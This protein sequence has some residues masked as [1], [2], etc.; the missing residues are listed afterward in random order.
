MLRNE[1]Q[2]AT[3]EFFEALNARLM[4][5]LRTFEGAW[6]PRFVFGLQW[7]ITD[8]CNLRCKHCYIDRAPRR[9]LPLQDLLVILDKFCAALRGWQAAGRIVLGGGEPFMRP[10]LWELVEAISAYHRRGY[11]LR[12]DFMTNGSFVDDQLVQQLRT[13]RRILGV[14]Q[15]SLDGCH[16]ETHDS[17]RGS[18]S[19]V[20]A[21]SALRRLRDAG[22]PTAIHFVLTRRN[23]S[24]VDG[25]LELAAELGASRVTVSRLVPQ[26]RAQASDMVTTDE[27]RQCWTRLAAMAYVYRRRGVFLATGRCDLWHLADLE[28]ALITLR[29]RKKGFLS[30][31]LAVGQRCPAGVNGLTVDVD[32]TVYPCRRLPI[33]VGNLLRD[34]FFTVWLDPLL[35]DL[36]R[37]AELLKGKCRECVFATEEDLSVLCLGGS[38]CQAYAIEGD[39]FAPDPNCWFDPIKANEE[40]IVKWRQNSF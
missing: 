14:V 6:K 4:S 26:G 38:P 17:I 37:R 35:N 12:V 13:Y 16:E 31:L 34:E 10:D 18:G 27:L 40:V 23:L 19:F 39:L 21:C 33:P 25:L 3:P 29:L 15:V 28:G 2:Q 5:I 8:R 22:I 1:E 9:D 24:D 32:G 30:P 7:H 11:P 20:A 36:R